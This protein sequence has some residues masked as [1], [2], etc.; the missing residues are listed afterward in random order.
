MII[1]KATRKV[2]LTLDF[3]TQ[4]T[5]ENNAQLSQDLS[6]ADKETP[7]LEEEKHKADNSKRKAL[8]TEPVMSR[9]HD[10]NA[11]HQIKYESLKESAEAKKG[12]NGGKKNK[13]RPA[14]FS[15]EQKEVLYSWLENNI[16]CPIPRNQELKNLAI[17]SGLSHAQIKLWCTNVR[18]RNLV[19]IRSSDET[20]SLKCDKTIKLRRETMKKNERKVKRKNID[21][22]E[23]EIDRSDLYQFM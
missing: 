11:N 21:E 20:M 1:N 17:C 8:D 18:R 15:L 9:G 10:S 5:R 22:S 12:A 3:H 19:V 6:A 4:A 14:N 2:L 23:S 16:E 7:Q 13:V